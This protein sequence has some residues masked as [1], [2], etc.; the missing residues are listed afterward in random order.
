YTKYTLVES[1]RNEEGKPRQ[2]TLMHLGNLDIDKYERKQLAYLLESKLI[3]Q[4]TMY[5]GTEIDKLATKIYDNYKLNNVI[6][7]NKEKEES[8]KELVT[9]DLNS[10][11]SKQSRSLG[12][13]ILGNAFY[14]RLG[15]DKILKDLKFNERQLAL[16]KGTII[17]RLLNPGS[18]QETLRWLKNRTSLVEMLD[19]DISKI[20]KNAL[21]EISDLLLFNKKNIESELRKTENILFPDELTIFL[22]DLTNTYFEGSCKNNNKA[23]RGKSKEKRSTAPL[24]TLALVVDGQGFPVFSQIYKGNQ[25]EP[26]TLKTVLEKL[27]EDENASLMNT[28]STIAM[29]RGIATKDN[30]KLLKEMKYPYIVIERREVEKDYKEEYNDYKN[31]FIEIKDSK[32]QSVYLK[33]EP[34]ESGGTRVLCLSEMRK[35][36]EESM[37]KKREE[38][39]LYDVNKL[40]T[41]IKKGNIKQEGKVHI[42][43]GRLKQ[44][45]SSI[46]KYYEIEV[47]V[48]EKGKNALDILANKKETREARDVLTG[49][50]VIETSHTNLSAE[51]AWRMY[52]LLTHVEKSFKA[53]KTD[54]GLRPV[55]HQIASR[56]EGHLFISVLAY[57]LLNSIEVTLKNNG[58]NK[59]FSTIK[60]E[61]QTHQRSTITMLSKENEIHE[62][63]LSGIEEENHKEIYSLLKIKNPLKRIYKKMSFNL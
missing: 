56:T 58:S 55:H 11:N 26:E 16:A 2:R 19:S 12:P 53:L 8:K 7:E 3:N 13:E 4:T 49:A 5:D 30:I 52:M 25:S 50:Y 6:H 1:Y 48:D 63:R 42:R 9:I 33:K 54:L 20:G 35:K 32:E 46:A 43:V 34:L 36:K 17:G 44:K 57:H 24:V 15:I 29:D 28:K 27:T 37:D 41:S 45:H 47:I 59:K 22:Y 60:N 61:L 14:E 62:I 18:E 51:E 40:R 31:T 39:F 21:Y 10:V 38:R 23:H